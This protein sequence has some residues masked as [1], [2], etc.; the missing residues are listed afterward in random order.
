MLNKIKQTTDFLN[1]R[2][3][4]TPRIG[5]ITGTGLGGITEEISADTEIPFNRIPNF[6]IS[7][8]PGHRGMLVAGTIKNIGV[9]VLNGRFH[10][11]EG[12]TPQEITFP[13]RIMSE[14]G[15][16][17]LLISSAAGGLNPQFETGD[18]MVVT[19]HINL[20]GQNPLA[21]PNLDALGPRFPDMS[22]AYNPDLVKLS[23]Q[24]ALESGILLRKGVYV[25][26]LGPSLET[27]AETRFIRM[28]GADAVGMSTVSEVIVAIH[29]GIKVMAIVAITNMNL[30][31][32][33]KESSAEEITATAEKTAPL[34][35]TLWKNIIPALPL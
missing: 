31:D 24:K 14:L 19:D 4:N 29:C 8:A 10:L 33:M 18:L 17:Y 2:L 35:S 11:Y 32:S 27:P 5:I 15:V 26:L 28:I 13:V 34:L 3:Q 9:V 6:P 22:R 21:G 12:Y 16:K 20:T 1:N 30:P 23:E 7:T 25:G